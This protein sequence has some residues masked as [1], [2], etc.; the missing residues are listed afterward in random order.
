MSDESGS[1]ETSI[2]PAPDSEPEV[3]PRNSD[4]ASPLIYKVAIFSVD[5]GGQHGHVTVLEDPLSMVTT[6]TYRFDPP[7]DPPPQG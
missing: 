7:T 3:R 5:V 4:A 1:R 6:Y 2:S